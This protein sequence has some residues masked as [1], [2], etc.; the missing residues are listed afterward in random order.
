M[1]LHQGFFLLR[2]EKQMM[3]LGRFSPYASH[4]VATLR[5]KMK[6]N[7]HFAACKHEINVSIR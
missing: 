2:G 7:Q 6:M 5:I 3:L 1:I 4:R